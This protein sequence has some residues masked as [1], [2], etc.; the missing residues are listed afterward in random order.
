MLDNYFF[1]VFF[2]LFLGFFG[3]FVLGGFL[4]VFCFVFVV[5]LVFLVLFFIFLV[6]GYL[7]TQGQFYFVTV[8]G[9]PTLGGC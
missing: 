6:Y 5:V 2:C 7:K 4:R 3:L 9:A 1:S 8:G